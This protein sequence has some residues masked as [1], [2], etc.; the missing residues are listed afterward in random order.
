MSRAYIYRPEHP[1]FAGYSPM[2]AL[3]ITAQQGGQA[4]G[5]TVGSVFPVVGTVIGSVI[6]GLV[7][8]LFG[9]EDHAKVNADVN[10]RQNLFGQW[11]SMGGQVPG[12]QIGLT[13]MRE[14]WKGAA[15]E[16]HFP[17]WQGQEQRIDYAIDGCNKCDP[18]TFTVLWPKAQQAGVRDAKT[19]IDQYFIPANASMGDHWAV[20]TDPIGYQVLYDTADAYLSQK[21]PGSPAY[22]ASPSSP[23]PAPVQQQP[24]TT[25]P[26]TTPTGQPLPVAGQG[27]TSQSLAAAGYL[28]AGRDAAGTTVYQQ[29]G[30]PLLMLVN[31][32]L[33]PYVQ[34]P[35][36]YTSS[37]LPVVIPTPQNTVLPSGQVVPASTVDPNTQAL[38]NQ[39]MS[40]GATQQQAFTAAMQALQQQGIQP[41]AAVQQQVANAMPQPIT[42]GLS[43]NWTVYAL[44]ALALLSVMFATARPVK[45]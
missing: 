39:L 25:M 43:G 20:P 38:I 14:I 4:V 12:R 19:F 6:G 3:G 29:P 45:S 30:G 15:H 21:A 36:S 17:K 33:R 16:G 32:Q 23:T 44:G 34:S 13:S 42:S 37:P 31:G 9:H 1:S 10:A 40:Q 18:N 27:V 11:A 5:A 7:G 28:I 2:G 41:T 26:V 24:A 35:V 22:V 8:G